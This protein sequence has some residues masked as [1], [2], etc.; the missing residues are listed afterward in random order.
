MVEHYFV[1][2]IG[3]PVLEGAARRIGIITNSEPAHGVCRHALRRGVLTIAGTL[4]YLASRRDRRALE[5]QWHHHP[6]CRPTVS[7]FC[8]APAG[9]CPTSI[10]STNRRLLACLADHPG[11]TWPS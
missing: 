6:P 4:R 3:A 7:L 2:V 1:D 8:Y 9:V 11:S 5:C 10:L